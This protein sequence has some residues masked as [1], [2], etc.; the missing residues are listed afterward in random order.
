MYYPTGER[1]F[2]RVVPPDQFQG[3]ADA[4]LAKRL[5]LRSVYVLRVDDPYGAVLASAFRTAARNLDLEIA[6]SVTWNPTAKGYARIADTVRKSGADGAFLG[7]TVYE[8]GAGLVRALRQRLGSRFTI[9]GGDGF[10]P[11]PNLLAETGPAAHGMYVSV[12]GVP[13]DELPPSGAEF[14]E[15]FASGRRGKA[16]GP[17]TVE[18][19]QAA[20]VALDAIARSD[21]TR[22][23]VLREVRTMEVGDGILGSFRFDG[24]GDIA[25]APV[26]IYRVTGAPGE[27]VFSQF[28]GAVVDQVIHVH[29]GVLD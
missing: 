23:S 3:A 15:A 9:I 14:V 24:N 11:I 2:L 12:T 6:G 5:Q 25:P 29:E 1:N 26:A 27:G 17:Y 28:R 8:G 4:I 18:A 10:H 22:T 20:E 13:L 21:G 7:G 19:A 16:T